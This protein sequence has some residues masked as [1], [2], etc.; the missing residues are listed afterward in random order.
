MMDDARRAKRLITTIY[1]PV[2]EMMWRL[3]M[4]GVGIRGCGV[5]EIWGELLFDKM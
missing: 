5:K 2:E 4:V 1:S 3:R